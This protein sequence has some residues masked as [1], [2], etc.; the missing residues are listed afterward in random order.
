[1]WRTRLCG[2]R[3]YV[4]SVSEDPPARFQSLIL[5]RSFRWMREKAS[6]C[7]SGSAFLGGDAEEL[8]HEPCFRDHIFLSYPPHAPFANHVH[9][10]YSFEGSSGTEK[11]FVS[12]GQPDSFFRNPVVL[13]DD[14]I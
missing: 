14:I 12:F 11:G 6:D 8:G 13:F 7:E 1:M 3:G 9:R 4:A 2:A 5:L 10:F